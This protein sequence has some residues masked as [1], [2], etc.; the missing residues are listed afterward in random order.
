VGRHR[1]WEPAGDAGR[2]K[3][4]KNVIERVAGVP[5]GTYVSR[6]IAS[7]HAE[8]TAYA[9]FDGHRSNDF[10]IYVYATSDYGETWRRITAG[11]PDNGAS[12]T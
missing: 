11:L 6:V 9:T 10:G 1:R 3:T 8:G 12:S 2:G 7:R 5:K 4:W